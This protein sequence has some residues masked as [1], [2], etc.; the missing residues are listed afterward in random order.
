M[1]RRIQRFRLVDTP[2]PRIGGRGPNRD[3]NPCQRVMRLRLASS[4]H[5][6]QTPRPLPPGSLDGVTIWESEKAASEKLGNLG[7]R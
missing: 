4:E 7:I 5:I 3:F 6:R 2:I 1:F